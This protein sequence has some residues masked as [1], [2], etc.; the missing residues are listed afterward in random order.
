MKTYKVGAV[1]KRCVE[2]TVKADSTEE[3]YRIVEE[4]DEDKI[5]SIDADDLACDNA[6][7]GINSIGPVV[8]LWGK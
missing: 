3:A 5:I 1:E 4:Y 6:E 2:Y 7:L 8:N